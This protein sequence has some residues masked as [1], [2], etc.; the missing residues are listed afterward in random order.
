MWYVSP[1]RQHV[2][3]HL[4]PSEY[5]DAL[6]LLSQLAGPS[7]AVV[8]A[9]GPTFG[10]MMDHAEILKDFDFPTAMVLPQR[11]ITDPIGIAR[12]VR[13]FAEAYGKPI[14]LYLKFANWMSADLIESMISDGLI[15]WI[16]Y[17]VVREDPSND[18]ELRTLIDT[19]GGSQ[20]ISGIGEQPAIVHMRDFGVRGFTSGCVCLAPSRSMEMLR[21]IQR[22]DYESAE[23]IRH[24]FAALEDLRNQINPIRV[25]HAV[26]LGGVAETGPLTPLLSEPPSNTIDAI[27]TAA[28]D[29]YHWEIEARQAI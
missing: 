9:V 21:A 18:P 14:V 29:L 13:K 25:L 6:T 27:Q 28:I 19:I 7:T 20:V 1:N 12:G 11:D 23:L 15:S 8:P 3:Y 24:R 10:L 17:A 4:R 26:E 2:F 22:G 16:K 5:A